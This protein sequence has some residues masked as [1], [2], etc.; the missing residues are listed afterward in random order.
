MVATPVGL[1][2]SSE[3]MAPKGPP[4]CKHSAEFFLKQLEGLYAGINDTTY[5]LADTSPTNP[6]LMWYRILIP[7]ICVFGI[8]GNIMNL[9]ILTR[10][11]LLARMDELE[12]CASYAAA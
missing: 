9:F 5:A 8:I 3:G 6:M 7:I 11:R 2:D 4:L 10:R 12:K 1:L